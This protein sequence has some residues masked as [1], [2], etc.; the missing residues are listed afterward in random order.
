MKRFLNILIFLLSRT[1]DAQ[2]CPANN[3]APITTYCEQGKGINTNPANPVNPECSTQFNNYDWRVKHTPGGLVPDERFWVYYQDD[4]NPTWIRNPFN[5]PVDATYTPFITANHGSNYQP[6]DGWELLKVDFGS[7]GNIGLG[8]DM[9]PGAN[10]TNNSR[11]KLPYMMLYNRYTGTLRF[12]G[13]LLEPDNTYETVRIE[14]LVSKESPQVSGQQYLN[15]YQNDL[16][17]TNLLSIQGESVQPLD[18]KTDESSIVVFV[19]Y[20]NNPQVFFWFDVPVAYDPCLCN[21]RAQ[22][23]VSFR[24]VQ[25]ADI[26]ISGSLSGSIKTEK[27]GSQDYAQMVFSRVLAAGVSGATA[28]ATKGAVVNVKAFID[29][30]DIVKP[31]KSAEQ[32]AS[33]TSLKNYLTCSEKLFSVVR[34]NYA[35]LAGSDEKKKL[36][37]GVKILDGSAIF[38][39]S[40]MSGCNSVDN[41][42]TTI[43]GAVKA[44]GT[45]TLTNEVEA[46]RITMALPGSKWNDKTLQHASYFENNGKLVPAYPTYHER[47]GVFALLET[48]EFEIHHKVDTCSVIDSLGSVFN[49]WELDKADLQLYSRHTYSLRLKDN[50]KYAFN[51]KLNLNN[52]RTE[53]YVRLVIKDDAPLFQI[54]AYRYRNNDT[55]L[56]CLPAY[57]GSRTL[58][59]AYDHESE[60]RVV[61]PFLPIDYFV[62]MPLRFTSLLRRIHGNVGYYI[63]PTEQA[64]IQQSWSA[65]MLNPDFSGRMF[66]QFKILGESG[67]RGSDGNPVTF[68]HLFTYPV[69]TA[70]A[71]TDPYATVSTGNFLQQTADF[72]ADRT[73]TASEDL[74]FEGPVFISAKLLTGSGAK[75]RIYS[76][77]GF[78]IEP[79]A[80]ISSDIELIVGPNVA[81]YSQ[82]AQTAAQIAAFCNNTDKYNARFFSEPAMA[83]AQGGDE[84]TASAM[85][86]AIRVLV[87][88]N[89]AQD[90]ITVYVQKADEHPYTITITDLTGRVLLNRRYPGVQ[91]VQHLDMA[92]FAHGVYSITVWSEGSRGTARVVLA[93]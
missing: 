91:A 32:Q 86:A 74:F 84:P 61:S 8:V 71:T 9:K 70:P 50:L 30:I 38:L 58:N 55:L 12:F 19:K 73:F 65:L 7:N 52:N 21:N 15:V 22:L 36:A 3:N 45:F 62:N 5:G 42:A 89:P 82:P 39:S 87:H 13:S 11:P 25:T 92:G 88:P 34:S 41:A 66:L 57:Q 75:V 72:N 10:T 23:D 37:A 33:L 83:E 4:N 81:P 1:L 63:D 46:T 31:G 80:E 47:L 35:D 20:T 76:L 59:M 51:P 77:K 24:F 44:S 67:N 60:F 16:K 2:N 43:T 90:N 29:L 49:N 14:L 69:K 40:L 48:P 68:Y 56:G 54:P 78:E 18:R 64:Q 26:D 27:K 93:R 53:V 85:H 79:G 17:A 6:E 28:I